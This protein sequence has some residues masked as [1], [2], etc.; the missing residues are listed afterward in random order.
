MQVL[1]QEPHDTVKASDQDLVIEATD[2]GEGP[3]C[4]SYGSNFTQSNGYCGY[5]PM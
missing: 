3:S 4:R 2:G 1:D 5:D